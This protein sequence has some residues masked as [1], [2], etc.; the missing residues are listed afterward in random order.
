MI[1]FGDPQFCQEAEAFSRDLRE[2]LEGIQPNSIESLRSLLIQL[3]QLEQALADAAV[4]SQSNALETL[5]DS[6]ELTDLAAL[7]FC[8][9]WLNCSGT[10]IPAFDST[11]ALHQLAQK[12]ADLSLPKEFPLTIKT[13]EGFEFY[14]LYPEQYCAS[15]RKWARDYPEDEA[16]LVVGIR[17][18]GTSLS[19][20]VSATLNLLGRKTFRL[21]VRPAG[22]PFERRVELPELSQARFRHALIVDEGPGLSGSSMAATAVALRSA[23]LQS[24]FFFPG[25]EGEPG[26]AASEKILQV[27]AETPRYLK[28]L[29]ELNWNG[30]SLLE[31]LSKK[32]SSIK[33]SD[34]KGDLTSAAGADLEAPWRFI[35][36]HAVRT[37]FGTSGNPRLPDSFDLIQDCSAGK[38]RQFAFRSTDEW[39][40]VAPQFERMKF[41][42]SDHEG[43]SVLWKFIGLGSWQP[44]GT[45]AETAAARLSRLA[46]KGFTVKPLENFQGFI[47]LPWIEG[48]RLTRAH[49]I[50]AHVLRRIGEYLLESSEPPLRTTEK[51]SAVARLAEMLFW[52]TKEALGDSLA[53]K[54]RPCANAALTADIQ[55]SAGDGHLAPHEWIFPDA[56]PSSSPSNILKL[57]CEGHCT[58]HTVIGPQPLYW[59]I[60]GALVEW[61]LDFA[62]AA[63]LLTPLRQAGLEIN[64]EALRFYELAYAAFRMGLMFLSLAQTADAP[65]HSRVQSAFFYYQGKLATKLKAEAL[66]HRSDR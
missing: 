8:S 11:N 5:S 66:P 50:D 7:A 15:A 3:G 57:D 27:W 20:I 6:R 56:A 32:T 25:H 16:V 42:C 19:A 49:A 12:L 63:P 43:H 65:E 4:A 26:S 17:S 30:L 47:A 2:L 62:D 9:A 38:W 60:A 41:R 29:D 35:Y 39:P 37:L 55:A 24:I 1:V 34:A 31:N 18:I 51:N 13:P 23:G 28:R 64:F 14:A 48:A 61:D 22:N 52:N 45:H 44:A 33:S 59:D 36:S 54:T 21:T 53:E 10:P 58:D 46:A 40:A